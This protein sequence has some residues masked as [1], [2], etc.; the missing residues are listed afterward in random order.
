MTTIW[1]RTPARVGAWLSGETWQQAR[2]DFSAWARKP[3]GMALMVIVLGAA[4]LRFWDLETRAVHHDESLHGYYS[5]FMADG[6]GI[7]A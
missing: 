5:W 2:A 4:I 6:G 7:H 1:R 3:E